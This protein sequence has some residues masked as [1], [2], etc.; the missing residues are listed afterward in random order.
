MSI[1][2]YNATAASTDGIIIPTNLETLA[3]HSALDHIDHIQ[4]VQKVLW[5]NNILHKGILGTVKT[6]YVKQDKD[7]EE[8]YDNIIRE[9]YPLTFE[10]IVPNRSSCEI[11]HISGRFFAEYD[12]IVFEKYHELADEI[13]VRDIE[14]NDVTEPNYDKKIGVKNHPELMG[15]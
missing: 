2:T 4:T 12:R 15:K 11:A 13:L 9:L 5:K 8:N 3:F 1:L 14:N 6:H 7:V 10:V